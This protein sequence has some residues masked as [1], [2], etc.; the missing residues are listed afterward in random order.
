MCTFGPLPSQVASLLANLVSACAI[1]FVNKA[2]LTVIGF[3]FTVT[4]TCIHTMATWLAARILSEVGVITR[5]RLPRRSTLALASAFA[6]YIILCNASL[7]LNTVGF[8]QLTKIAIA[9][10]VMIMQAISQRR[11]PPVNISVCVLTACVGIGLATVFDTQVMTNVPGLIIGVLSVA[12][13]S[14]YGIWIGSMTKKHSVTSMQLLEQ[15][16]PYASLMMA[17]CVPLE[18]M[19]MAITSPGGATVWT[20]AY[21]HQAIAMIAVS[22]TLGIVVTFSTFLVIGHTSPLTYAIVGH[23][24]TVFILGGGVVMFGDQISRIKMLGIMMALGGVFAYT[25]LKMIAQA[26]ALADAATGQRIK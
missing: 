13:S 22:A 8:Y 9:P 11:Y 2:V 10:T 16:L 18:S 25:R 20:F 6:G 21:S 23:V 7:S 14:Q 5:K 17:I 3:R 15:Y 12:V 19:A 26:K 1:V 4:L 24:K